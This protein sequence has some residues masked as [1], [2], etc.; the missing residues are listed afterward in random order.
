MSS[1][2][3]FDGLYRQADPFGYHARWYEQRK[4][5]LLL[6]CLPQRHYARG[7]ELGCANGVLTAAL[8]PRCSLLLGTDLSEAALDQARRATAAWPH[9]RLARACHPSQWPAGEFDLI[10]VGEMG[11]YLDPPALARLAAGVQARLDPAGLLVACHWRHP[12]DQ[13]RSDAATVHRLLGAGLVEVFAYRDADVLLQGWSRQPLSVA[14][15]EGL[16]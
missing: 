13:A 2:A 7:W 6:A 5:A 1:Q 12:F 3:Y 16:R 11:Y 9:V 8:A 14:A 15:A 10:V 4:R